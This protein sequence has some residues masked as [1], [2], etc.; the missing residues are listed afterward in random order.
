MAEL[1]ALND[2]LLVTQC[3]TDHSDCC[4]FSVAG[5]STWNQLPADVH[6]ISDETLGFI[7]AVET[8]F[9]AAE[10]ISEA[11]CLKVGYSTPSVSPVK[12]HD[13]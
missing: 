1:H 12:R 10:N 7:A 9:I 2:A 3:A 4:A 13:T 11:F 6:L 8:F 5:C